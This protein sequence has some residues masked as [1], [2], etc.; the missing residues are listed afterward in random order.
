[1]RL[2]LKCAR[3]ITGLLLFA[4]QAFATRNDVATWN[5][6]ACDTVVAAQ[7]DPLTNSRIL[8]ILHIAVH[9]A[10][11]AIE[12]R[13][14]PYAYDRRTFF[15]GSLEAAIATASHDVLVT[16]VPARQ[17]QLDAVY[18]EYMSA[19]PDGPA[20]RNGV[21]AGQE[22]S[23]R[24]L[25]QRASDGS[26]EPVPAPNGT[27]P[28]AYRP[29]PPEFIPPALPQWGRVTPF[30]LRTPNQFRPVPP[31]ALD[32]AQYAADYNEVRTLGQDTSAVRTAEQSQIARH[33]Y[34]NSPEG[35]NRIARV[36]LA[37]RDLNPWQA[38]RLFALLNIA[39]AD[40]F[41]GGFE[42]KY[43]YN[44]WRPVTAIQDG[45]TDGNPGTTAD[46]HWQPFL[47]TPPVPDYPSTHSVLGGAAAAVLAR[48]FQSDMVPF[49]FTSGVP[50]A[51]T[52]RPYW[53]FSEAAHENAMSRVM[54]G[55]HFRF[56]SQAGLQQGYEIGEYVAETAL[57]PLR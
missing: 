21:R 5:A 43:H 46:A 30:A 1:M 49:S 57:R 19:I 4:A 34:E 40:G 54:A 25:A 41:I 7:L 6:I 27:L 42:A 28:G 52:T 35:W 8:A 50:F 53:S 56:A 23:A 15:G 31:P 10:V 32:S 39:M 20:G 13:Y 45:A 37:Q 51:G 44:T 26:A 33:W 38:A 14:Q 3:T 29:T 24:I 12:P 9:D 36:V 47:P 11:N 22:A 16:L 55:L 2:N 48:V 18:Q 17:S